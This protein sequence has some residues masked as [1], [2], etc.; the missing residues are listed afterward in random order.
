MEKSLALI[1]FGVMLLQSSIAMAVQGG[2][3]AKHTRSAL[4]IGN[5]AY[6]R[7]PL[8]NPVN[9]A[10][11]MARALEEL[12]FEVMLLTNASLR[13]FDSAVRTFGSKLRQRGGAGLFYYAGHGMQVKGRNYLIPIDASIDTESDVKFEAIDAGR[14]L[15]K[16]EDAG[17]PINIVILDACRDNPFARQFRSA[18]R[19]LARM[20][21]PKGSLVAYATSPGSVAADGTDRNGIYTTYLLQH[22]RTPGLTLEQ[23]LKNVRI[24]VLTATADAQIPWESSSMTGDFYFN[25]PQPSEKKSVPK[26]PPPEKISAPVSIVAKVN[27]A[28][29]S[30]SGPFLIDN[31]EDGDLFSD[32]LHHKWWIKKTGKPKAKIKIDPTRGARGSKASLQL[33]YR[34]RKKDEIF[35]RVGQLHEDRVVFN[36]SKFDKISFY[37]KS[38]KGQSFLSQPN[39]VGMIIFSYD[40]DVKTSKKH[41]IVSYWS[42][43]KVD[44]RPTTEWQRAEFYFKDCIPTGYT[45]KQIAGYK[46]RPTLG[47]TVLLSFFVTSCCNRGKDEAN[48]IWIDEVYLE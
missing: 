16:M 42:D 30:S 27:T 26:S 46:P 45:K 1:C 40:P 31:F 18:G 35:L 38:K 17:N 10:Q 14:I 33:N 20:D 41:P 43:P 2:A 13:Q 21:A 24:D 39:K 15:G 32:N 44:V 9:D 3:A 29:R 22:M 48:T 6:E 19:G 34:V 23:V 8:K 7:M 37:I 11:D 47:Q 5:D 12:G 28:V 25:P 4:V 36:F